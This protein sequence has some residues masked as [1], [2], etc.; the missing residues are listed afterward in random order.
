MGSDL[1]VAQSGAENIKRDALDQTQKSNETLE[2]IQN[3]T[4]FIN[5]FLT[6]TY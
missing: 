3:I 1:C 2:A 6:N 5:N 4:K